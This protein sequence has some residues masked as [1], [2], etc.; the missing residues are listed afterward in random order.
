MI[1]NR[2]DFSHWGWDI[3]IAVLPVLILFLNFDN[4]SNPLKQYY[5]GDGVM[6]F[7][8]IAIFFGGKLLVWFFISS[9]SIMGFYSAL[10][11]I[12]N[13]KP[14]SQQFV[15]KL[16]WILLRLGTIVF[17]LLILKKNIICS[18]V[19]WQEYKLYI[20][21]ILILLTLWMIF[22][23]TK[24]P[25]APFP[26]IIACMV[27][28]CA[29]FINNIYKREL[30]KE[31]IRITAVIEDIRIEE[32]KK[33]KKGSNYKCQIDYRF[34]EI[35][36]RYIDKNIKVTETDKLY[37]MNIGD[38]IIVIYSPKCDKIRK[39]VNLFPTSEEI[40]KFK[41]GKLYINEKITRQ[42]IIEW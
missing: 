26:I 30:K 4:L 12:K 1:E 27:T 20:I 31:H 19:F 40:E 18:S 17:V 8:S 7:L 5:R 2:K 14:R 24:N 21:I 3:L 28:L 35:K 32:P 16:I 9:I 11:K 39:V 33:Y 6:G 29:I 41:Q 38:N 15:M 13:K 36:S 23:K 10:C 37:N 25:I 34:N 42:I 22:M